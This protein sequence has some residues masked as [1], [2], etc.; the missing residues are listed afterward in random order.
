MTTDN[1][2]DNDLSSAE[3]PE[4][5]HRPTPFRRLVKLDDRAV[6]DIEQY[7]ARAHGISGLLP[8]LSDTETLNQERR[9]WNW[10]QLHVAVFPPPRENSPDSDGDDGATIAKPE[11]VD[12]SVPGEPGPTSMA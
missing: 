6:I 1:E 4:L 2:E 11:P 10:S 12:S 7:L 5:L 9:G 8:L 3:E